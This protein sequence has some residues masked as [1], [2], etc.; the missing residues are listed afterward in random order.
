MDFID[1]NTAWGKKRSV[2]TMMRKRSGFITRDEFGNE[3]EQGYKSEIQGVTLKDNPDVGH[4]YDEIVY[5]PDGKM[6]WEDV[7]KGTTLFGTDGSVT[8]VENLIELGVTDV[9]RLTLSDGRTVEATDN[10]KWEVTRY[11]HK[12]HS[13]NGDHELKELRKTI[14]TTREIYELCQN[15]SYRTNKCRLRG[16]NIAE[17]P[18]KEVPIDAYTLGLLLGDGCIKKATKSRVPITQLPS[19]ME[20]IKSFIPYVVKKGNSK[21]D[22][23]YYIEI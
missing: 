12:K 14:L 1:K 13:W 6:C 4:P 20:Y 11:R 16:A 7:Q 8:T 21:R 2:N 15:K 23:D 17:F 3:V 10:H 19:D 9:Y 18:V 5:T 22:I